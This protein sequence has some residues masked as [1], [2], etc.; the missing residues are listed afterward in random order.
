MSGAS[1]WEEFR[2][3]LAVARQATLGKA[4]A[5]L[6]VNHSTVFRKLLQLERHFNA[7]LFE[8]RPAGI[9]IPTDIGQRVVRAA[10]KME[11]H[12][13]AAL[14]DVA[15]AER[16]LTGRLRVTCSETLAY[17]VLAPH[18]AAFRL[19]HPG[20]QLSLV[21]ENRVLDLSRQ[22]TDI[23]LRIQRPRDNHLWGR[24]LAAIAIGIYA[25]RTA[26]VPLLERPEDIA[27]YPLIGWEDAT[28]STAEWLHRIVPPDGIAYRT[29]SLIHQMVVAREGVGL[30]V[31]P[32]YLGDS[33][34][35]LRRVLAL[36]IPGLAPELWI[37]T[38]RDLR[39][40][41][42]I[43]V[44]FDLVGKGI[45]AQRA[46]LGGRASVTPAGAAARP[47]SRGGKKRSASS[48]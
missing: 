23:A 47:R 27:R 8:R 30:A 25:A 44:F 40:S 22:E 33:E 43:R 21:V 17:R 45:A 46:L 10:E 1:K 9:Y 20:I 24:K 37:V 41:P 34:P 28:T 32:C 19:A 26:P 48:A 6:G 3:V 11:D 42:R 16:Q 12:A 7:Q 14:R 15:G 2:L 38:H 31:L 39:N 4:A 35:G 29:N 5:E 18:V 13:F 36:P